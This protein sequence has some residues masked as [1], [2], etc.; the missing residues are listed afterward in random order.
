MKQLVIWFQV[1]LLYN[2]YYLTDIVT[3]NLHDM[4]ARD[5]IGVKDFV[6]V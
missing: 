2:I 4:C 5:E 1:S 3:I 6:S